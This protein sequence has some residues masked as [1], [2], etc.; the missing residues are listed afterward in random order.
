VVKTDL[1][2]NELWRR[3]FGKTES[4]WINSVQLTSDGGI[5]LAGVTYSYGNGG[6]D[7]W[8]IK[9]SGDSGLTPTPNPM[10]TETSIPLSSPTLTLTPTSAPTSKITERITNTP[11]VIESTPMPI[12]PVPSTP[13]MPGFEII[14]TIAGICTMLYLIKYNR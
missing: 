8:L 2:G 9:I 7:A 1:N 4:D 10:T 14:L 5:I 6:S 13:R 11:K 12:T 3:T